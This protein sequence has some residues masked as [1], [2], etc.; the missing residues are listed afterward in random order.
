[1]RLV[2]DVVREPTDRSAALVGS[3]FGQ[4]AGSTSRTLA[5]CRDP[6]LPAMNHPP[7]ARVTLRTVRWAV[8][9]PLP[10]GRTVTSVQLT[11]LI[12]MH[13]PVVQRR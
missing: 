7:I 8:G 3:D 12:V 6:S 4:I 11:G 13:M 2:L 9:R 5:G 10:E 1:M